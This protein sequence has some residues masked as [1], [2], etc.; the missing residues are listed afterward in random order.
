MSQRIED[1]EKSFREKLSSLINSVSK[2][3]GSNTPD[4]ILADYLSGCL[5][6]FDK[7][8]NRREKWYGRP[9]EEDSVKSK[10]LPPLPNPPPPIE[11]S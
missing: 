4:F 5:E 9:D 2:E 1:K 6:N 3:N 7:A 8:V 10:E 11:L